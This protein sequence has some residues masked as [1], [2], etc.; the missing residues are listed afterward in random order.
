MLL[1]PHNMKKV[2]N[3]FCIICLAILFSNYTTLS[4]KTN[5]YLETRKGKVIFN[6]KLTGEMNHVGNITISVSQDR[7]NFLVTF[8]M[9]KGWTLEKSRVFIGDLNE[10]P[11]KEN[12]CPDLKS[13]T[14]RKNHNSGLKEYSYTIPIQKIKKTDCLSLLSKAVA[15]KGNKK[16]NA[17][18]EGEKLSCNNKIT[19]SSLCKLSR[20]KKV[21]K[22]AKSKINNN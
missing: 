1:N 8:K 18:S 4:N 15:T 17:W 2:K 6:S 11:L 20:K 3:L 12:G 5:P 7:T 10:L 16:V 13:I 21:L 14:H 22:S 19:Y 9:K